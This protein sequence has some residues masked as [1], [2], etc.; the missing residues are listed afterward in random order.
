MSR[1][2]N[3]TP[4]VAMNDLAKVYWTGHVREL[5]VDHEMAEMYASDRNDVN[6]VKALYIAGLYEEMKIKINCL[7]TIVRE[8]VIIAMGKDVGAQFVSDTLGWDVRGWV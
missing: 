3:T 5:G 4:M 8:E 6:D 1:P 2:I 7:D